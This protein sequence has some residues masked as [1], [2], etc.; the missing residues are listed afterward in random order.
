[1]RYHL[2]QKFFEKVVRIKE[3]SFLL[4]KCLVS[5]GQHCNYVEVPTMATL[6][7]T[8]STLIATRMLEFN[9]RKRYPLTLYRSLVT[10]ADIVKT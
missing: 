10:T 3:T 4:S 2:I 5:I 9:R 7:Y 1:M 8:T 6:D